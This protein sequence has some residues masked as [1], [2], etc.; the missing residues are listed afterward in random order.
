[1]VW[2]L[3]Q[4]GNMFREEAHLVM[5]V[6]AVPELVRDRNCLHNHYGNLYEVNFTV[7]F[8]TDLQVED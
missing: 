2:F 4:L 5:W 7:F 8:H 1:M 6:A 3:W